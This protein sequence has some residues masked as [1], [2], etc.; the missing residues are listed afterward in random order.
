MGGLAYPEAFLTATRQYVAQLLTISLDEL[1]LKAELFKGQEMNQQC[2]RVS[3]FKI[4][5]ADWDLESNTLVES[6]QIV[7][8]L[9]DIVFSWVKGEKKV[10]VEEKEIMCPVYLNSLRNVVLFSVKLNR[11][12]IPLDNLY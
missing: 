11:G 1:E 7:N 10:K 12:E 2:F 8:K 6:N 3:Q 5:G 9:P 4:E